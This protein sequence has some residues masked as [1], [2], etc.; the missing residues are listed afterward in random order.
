MSSGALARSE[1]ARG[2]VCVCQPSRDV[3]DA[4]VTHS[5]LCEGARSRRLELD[6]DVRGCGD[7]QLFSVFGCVARGDRG[8]VPLGNCGPHPTTMF[9]EFVA[10]KS[11]SPGPL[12]WRLAAPPAAVAAAQPAH[13]AAHAGLSR[14]A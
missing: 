3:C 2:G 4:S 5:T 12:T 1:F 6:A 9:S 10:N 7:A 8:C 13:A 11:I 14:G